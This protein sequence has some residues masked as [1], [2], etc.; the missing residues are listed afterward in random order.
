[1][2][3]P[4]TIEEIGDWA[5]AHAEHLTSVIIPR[6]PISRGKELF[7]GCKRLREIVFDCSQREWE[8]YAPL[9]LYR[10]LAMGVTVL[11]DYV[12][13]DPVDFGN[14][15]W[16]RRWDE[17]LSALV[18]LDDLD[19]FE[20]LWTC[21]EEDYEGKD[22]D[23]KSYPVE[24]RKMKLRIV[25]FRL[26]HPYKIADET[27]ETFRAYLRSHTKGTEAPEAWELLIEE[28]ADDL[29]YYRVFAD[30]GCINEDNFDGLLADMKDCSAELK[31]YLLRYKEEHFAAKDAFAAFELDW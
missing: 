28:H 4:A 22:Y 11:H 25:Y 17:K 29:E 27:L 20:E 19:G 2:H 31:A 1:I 8:E 10:M 23:I 24:K 5:F 16:V 14:D 6:R 13:F 15:A 21:G 7:L 3:L 9:G 30:S 18:A 12:L 26:M